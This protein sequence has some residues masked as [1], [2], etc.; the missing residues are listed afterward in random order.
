MSAMAMLGIGTKVDGG[1]PERMRVA[2]SNCEAVVG[3]Y[4]VIDSCLCP[5]NECAHRDM[6]HYCI[7]TVCGECH[8]ILSVDYMH[9][10]W[11]T[12]KP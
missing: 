11:T 3:F 5:S 8:Q 1:T 4:A 2:C 10:S 9:A 7:K 12:E 6:Q